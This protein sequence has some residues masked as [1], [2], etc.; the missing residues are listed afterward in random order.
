MKPL[1][2][3]IEMTTLTTARCYL[4]EPVGHPRCHQR[5]RADT[6]VATKVHVRTPLLPPKY[7][8]GY[9]CCHQSIR[10]DTLR[11]RLQLEQTTIHICSAISTMH[12]ILLTIT[13]NDLLRLEAD[14]GGGGT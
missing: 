1:N 10:A 12:P 7:T 9:P 6:H 8:C 11:A 14:V 4:I 2:E 13:K 3:R 5:T